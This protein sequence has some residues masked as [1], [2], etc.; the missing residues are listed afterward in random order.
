MKVK[1]IQK[2][3]VNN[4]INNAD[5]VCVVDVLIISAQVEKYVKG[6]GL[7]PS[8]I[9]TD[10]IVVFLWLAI[11]KWLSLLVAAHFNKR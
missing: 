4:G 2:V 3:F 10:V 5:H 1:V 9:K 8:R 6:T 7:R 11:I